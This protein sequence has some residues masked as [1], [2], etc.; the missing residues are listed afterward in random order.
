MRI[1]PPLELRAWEVL[2]EGGGT[3][4][5]PDGPSNYGN[6]VKPTELIVTVV[7]TE[8]DHAGFLDREGI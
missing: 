1:D 8:D 4:G 7:V 2:I 5:D 3:V 6:W